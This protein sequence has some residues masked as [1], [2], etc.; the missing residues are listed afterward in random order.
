VFNMTSKRYR[1]ITR[2]GF[3]AV[4]LLLFGHSTAAPTP[5]SIQVHVVGAGSGQGEIGCALFASP[6]G[7]PMSPGKATT[8]WQRPNSGSATCRFDGLEPGRYAV[9][10]SQ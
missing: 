7:F 1:N 4:G 3:L 8:R 6:D 10:V 2:G 5:G 9:A